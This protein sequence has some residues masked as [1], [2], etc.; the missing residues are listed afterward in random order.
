MCLIKGDRR[1]SD[2]FTLHE[3]ESGREAGMMEKARGLWK[4]KFQRGSF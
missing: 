4:G 1:F 2:E 3:M